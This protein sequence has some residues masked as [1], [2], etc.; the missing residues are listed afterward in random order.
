MPIATNVP[1]YEYG[2]K[3]GHFNHQSPFFMVHDTW[4]RSEEEIL[5]KIQNWGHKT[6]FDVMKYFEFWNGTWNCD[7]RIL[8]MQSHSHSVVTYNSSSSNYWTSLILALMSYCINVMNWEVALHSST[9]K[10]TQ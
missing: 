7:E 3:N 4:A 6:D 10:I 2:R 9:R 5:Q 1:I 8:R